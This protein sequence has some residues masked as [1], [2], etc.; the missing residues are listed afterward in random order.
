[1]IAPEKY[2]A[3]CVIVEN[4]EKRLVAC[5]T[6]HAA[7]APTATIFIANPIEKHRTRAAPRVISFN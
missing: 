4:Q 3:R 1:M 6:L 2:F 7:T 5:E